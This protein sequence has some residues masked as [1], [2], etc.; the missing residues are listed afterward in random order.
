[1]PVIATS[2]GTTVRAQSFVFG[3]PPVHEENPSA[4]T[5]QRAD[6]AAH[7]MFDRGGTI[8]ADHDIGL[9]RKLSGGSHIDQ[10]HPPATS[11]RFVHRHAQPHFHIARDVA[12]VPVVDL[13]G[14]QSLI[15]A[16]PRIRNAAR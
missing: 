14:C 13:V 2:H 11:V 3:Y 15:A 9:D 7:S 5:A 6:D 1:V 10:F 4:S 12:A 16:L 8:V